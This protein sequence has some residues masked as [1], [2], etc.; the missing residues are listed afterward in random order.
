MES[1][2][3]VLANGEEACGKELFGMSY[4]NKTKEWSPLNRSIIVP[5]CKEFPAFPKG[6]KTLC[7]GT[8]T[9][10]KEI[11]LLREKDLLYYFSSEDE[12]DIQV[13]RRNIFPNRVVK[14]DIKK[15]CAM[16]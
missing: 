13:Q 7:V 3:L 5:G 15:A 1:G 11:V 2:Q 12:R 6:T 10:T 16:I 4:D 8:F 9:D 14:T